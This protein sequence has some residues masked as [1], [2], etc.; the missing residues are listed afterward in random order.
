MVGDEKAGATQAI[1]FEH[2]G[3]RYHRTAR[4]AVRHLTAAVP[5]G[6]L[7]ALV[8]PNGSGK[9]TLLRACIGFEPSTEGRVTVFGHDP[10]RERAGV[11]AKVAYVPQAPALYPS[12]TAREH[13]DL[14][15][16][17][18]GGFDRDRAE[19]LLVEAGVDPDRR[20]AHLSGG[21]QAQVALVIALA[22]LAPLVLLDEP[23]A[24]LDPLARSTFLATLAVDLRARRATALVSS[25]LV[26][27]LEGVCDR[28]MVVGGGR[29][30]LDAEVAPTLERFRVR[31]A[32]LAGADVVGSYRRTD[33]SIVDLVTGGGGAPPTLEDVVLGHLAKARAG[34]ADA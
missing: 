18:R 5:A 13:W 31:P 8:G 26:R 21:E 22:T 6:S 34:V 32:S 33:G 3:R 23:L 9:S 28:L 20:V 25:H 19:N 17:A 4:W 2:Y 11:L 29:L 30:L 14:A 7:T 1:R 24:S 16:V 27:D 12:L 15:R 10:V